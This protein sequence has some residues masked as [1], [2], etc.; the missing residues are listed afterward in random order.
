M[1]NHQ[2]IVII[3]AGPAG[4]AAANEAVRRDLRP[5]VLEK[6]EKVGGLAR[7]ETYKGYRFDVGGHRF[8]TK[9]R[10]VDAMWHEILREDFL[11]RPRMSRIYYR[12]KFFNYPLKPLNALLGLGP[13]EA[14]RIIAEAEASPHYVPRPAE[15]GTGT[16]E[17]I[18]RAA[19]DVADQ[20]QARANVVLS[21]TASTARLVSQARPTRPVI[22]VA[23]EPAAL[24]RMALF[25][26]IRPERHDVGDDV[27]ELVARACA[28]LKRS[29]DAASGDRLVLI[30]GTPLTGPGTT[31]SIRVVA[32]P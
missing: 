1:R 26:G 3:G 14:A 21:A 13:I 16:D 23:L 29:G 27:E 6:A 7:T 11:T 31:N 19:C 28:E 10:E 17:A 22:G 4:L 30:F 25:W 32:I 24:R 9:S 5:I 8:F 15:V 18:A 12:N 2:P 20:I